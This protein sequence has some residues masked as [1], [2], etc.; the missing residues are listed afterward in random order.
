MYAG[1]RYSYIPPVYRARNLLAALDHNAH[2]N[3]QPM[4]NKD[5]TIRLVLKQ[6]KIIFFNVKNSAQMFIFQYGV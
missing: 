4:K 6:P 5:G 2:L 1:K 3:R